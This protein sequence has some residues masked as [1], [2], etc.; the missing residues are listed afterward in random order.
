MRIRGWRRRKRIEEAVVAAVGRVKRKR[1]S[2]E[3]G[4]RGRKRRREQRCSGAGGF[5]IKVKNFLET[6]Q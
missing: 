5:T 1:M 4:M 6:W 2:R 3:E